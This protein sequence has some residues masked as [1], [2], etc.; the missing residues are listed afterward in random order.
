MYAEDKRPQLTFFALHPCIYLSTEF[1]YI[2]P[3]PC[4]TVHF[5][6]VNKG[7]WCISVVTSWRITFL[8]SFKCF[9]LHSLKLRIR[10]LWNMFYWKFKFY[11][12]GTR[13]QIKHIL[14]WCKNYVKFAV[15]FFFWKPEFA[16]KELSFC[17]KFK[18]S[19]PYIL[20]IW[21]WKPLIFQT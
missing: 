4:S 11:S 14:I 7:F 16:W 2:P 9:Y 5:I 21:W 8:Y 13:H 20:G 3:R 18:F 19:N 15:Y 6:F 1:V 17:H 10:V 12:F